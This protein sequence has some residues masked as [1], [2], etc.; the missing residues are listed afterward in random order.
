MPFTVNVTKRERSRKL[1]SG[2]RVTHVRWVVNYK[3]PRTGQRRQ[4][5]FEKK[6]DA[7]AKRDELLASVATG[8]Y[9]AAKTHITVAAAVE[10]WLEHRRSEVKANTMKGY[11]DGARLIIK[12]LL[13]GA[14][15]QQRELFTKT[16]EKPKD[17]KLEPLL[18][19]IKL[20]ELTTAD[21]R[22]WYK[23]VVQEVGQYSAGR[24]KRFL[25]AA[26]RL[27][28]E[29]LRI[30]ACSMPL[31]LSKQKQK[32]KKAILPTEEVRR[33]I[34]AARLDRDKGVYYAFPFLAGTRPSEQLALLWEDV[35]F[36]K[37]TI[38]ICRM[39]ERNGSITEL[40]KTEAGTR[41]VPM[42][43]VLK[44]MLL[45]WRLICPRLEAELH[46]VF[47]GPGRLDKDGRKVGV[48]GPLQYQNFRSRVWR[49]AFERLELPYI[50]PHAARHQWISTMQAQGIE[51]GLVAK[52]AGHANASIT[53]SHYT[54]AVRN[55][56]A[57]VKALEDAYT[58]A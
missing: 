12:P 28:E 23:L 1:K 36:A 42:G 2:E 24:A 3:E 27:A 37:G 50:S 26:L 15:A 52:L 34:A 32:A 11:N 56:D 13:V 7:N 19:G 57:A 45:E 29:D 25:N 30:K 33:L 20:N 35:D 4:L 9:S 17:A 38:R 47:P 54:Q 41:E 5:F 40:T 48:G 51:V 58:L 31:Y 21:I 22:N 8:T 39:Q 6:A 18:G 49:K 44:A 55:G 14:T 53:L 46:R 10:N 43:P 16:G